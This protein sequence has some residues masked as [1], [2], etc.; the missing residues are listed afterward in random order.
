MSKI[1][2]PSDAL[3]DFPDDYSNSVS[4]SSRPA[5]MRKPSRVRSS[6]DIPPTRVKTKRQVKINYNDAD[7]DFE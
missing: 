2:T 7:T 6:E 5:P 1:N 3:Y 4:S